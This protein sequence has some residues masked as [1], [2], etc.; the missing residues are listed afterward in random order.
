MSIEIITPATLFPVTLDEAKAHLRVDFDEDDT[1]INSL[2]KSATATAENYLNYKLLST[3][4]KEY[5]SAFE[6]EMRLCFPNVTAI[7]E[8][9][10]LDSS[11]TETDATITDFALLST[12]RPSRLILKTGKELPST[13]SRPDAV[14]IIYVTG[15]A[16]ATEIDSSIKHAILLIVGDYYENREDIHHVGRTNYLRVRPASQRLLDPFR[17]WEF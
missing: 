7:S 11:E 12:F 17:L 15:K 10:Y 4:V 13:F 8:I 9:K 14:R 2:I 16:T 5:R 3:T 6:K 1:Y